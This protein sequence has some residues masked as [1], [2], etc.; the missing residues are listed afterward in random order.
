MC[1]S[2]QTAAQWRTR[3]QPVICSTAAGETGRR[4]LEECGVSLGSTVN[5]PIP[6]HQV[7]GGEGLRDPLGMWAGREGRTQ[8]VVCYRAGD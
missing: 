3:R 7:V 1:D 8:E 6:L 5:L 4:D 2:L